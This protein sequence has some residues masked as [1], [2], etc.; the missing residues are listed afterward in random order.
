MVNKTTGGFIASGAVNVYITVDGGIQQAS[1][2]TP[3]YEG[4]G[5][6]SITFTS[7]ETDGEVIGLLF[8]HANA[9]IVQ[10]TIPTVG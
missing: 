8:T 7:L 3:E 5:Q 2:N 6:W 4:N 9:V 1:M 10:K